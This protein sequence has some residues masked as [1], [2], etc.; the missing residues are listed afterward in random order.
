MRMGRVMF[1][2]LSRHVSATL[3]SVPNRSTPARRCPRGRRHVY[4]PRSAAEQLLQRGELFLGG[5]LLALRSPAQAES[6]SAAGR[7]GGLALGDRGVLRRALRGVAGTR[8][9]LLGLR[10]LA[11]VRAGDRAH[12]GNLRHAA[13]GDR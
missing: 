7:A 1:P 13:L 8:A 2:T 5:G 11:A 3:D 9:L 10:L 6:G 12:S 4:G